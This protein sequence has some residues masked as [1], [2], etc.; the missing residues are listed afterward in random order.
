MTAEQPGSA[1]GGRGIFLR[2]GADV[3]R[4]VWLLG[5]QQWGAN[6]GGRV[7]EG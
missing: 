4:V 7:C 3:I 1:A 6:V 5:F 2:H